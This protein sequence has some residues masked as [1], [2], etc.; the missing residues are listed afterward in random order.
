MTL[1]DLED[2]IEARRQ[3]I[4][5][6]LAGIVLLALMFGAYLFGV[7]TSAPKVENIAPAAE[8]S[9][10][11][12]SVVAERQPVAGKPPAAPHV[13]PK[14]STE[15]RR[16]KVTVRPKAGIE[17]PRSVLKSLPSDCLKAV[18]SAQCP[19]VTVDLSLVRQGDGRRVVASSPDGLSPRSMF[20]LKREPSRSAAHGQLACRVTQAS[21]SKPRVCGLSETSAGSG[22]AQKPAG[23]WAVTRRVGFA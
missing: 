5:W 13:L 19:D 11:D 2:Q 21:A 12:G 17:L 4:A 10:P 20:R 6:G 14:G 18:E 7:R 15:E 1:S 9:Q 16:A 23:R 3:K 22:W 8:Q